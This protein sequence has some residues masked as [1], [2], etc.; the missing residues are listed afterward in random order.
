MFGAWY[1]SYVQSS[2][3]MADKGRRMQSCVQTELI[4]RPPAGKTRTL[5]TDQ[6]KPTLL[7][8]ME[9]QTSITTHQKERYRV[10]EWSNVS[11]T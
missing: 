2:D 4:W 1:A 10:N 7:E 8:I 11:I 3:F 5:L 9:L 6:Q